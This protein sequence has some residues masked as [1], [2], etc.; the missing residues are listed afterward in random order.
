MVRRSLLQAEILFQL[1]GKPAPTITELAR[2]VNGKRPSVSRSLHRLEEQGQVRH[3]QDGWTLTEEGK[4]E[5]PKAK[6]R[7]L[8]LTEE[9]GNLAE[10]TGNVVRRTGTLAFSEVIQKLGELHEPSV[11]NIAGDQLETLRTALKT[12]TVYEEMSRLIESP[13]L[14]VAEQIN[15][16]SPWAKIHQ[17]MES[18]IGDS[19]GPLRMAV[20]ATRIHGLIEELPVFNL[21]QKLVDV[22]ELMFGTVA[23]ES[24]IRGF[25]EIVPTNI[26]PM[27]GRMIDVPDLNLAIQE[28]VGPLLRTQ[29]LNSTLL[30]NLAFAPQITG[31][32]ELARNNHRLLADAIDDVLAL[33]SGALADWPDL[34]GMIDFPHLLPDFVDLNVAYEQLFRENIGRLVL[35]PP[36]P[37]Y[38]EYLVPTVAV[39]SYAG[40]VR[41][42]IEEELIPYEEPIQQPRQRNSD[43]TVQEELDDMLA[44]LDVK[45]V[46]MR[47]GCWHALNSR[48]PDYQRHAAVSQRELVVQVL[49]HLVP[50]STLPTDA[51]QGPQL[52]ARLMILA[53][54][55]K[56]DREF[57][58]ALAVAVLRAYDQLNKYTHRDQRQESALRA[59][60]TAGEALL[61]FVLSVWRGSEKDD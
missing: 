32:E 58:E 39:S 59:I 60:L 43:A 45:F 30:S 23:G 21:A 19:T 11:I 42:L 10:R 54:H 48:G 51:R 41:D 18:S 52:K 24:A 5:V 1:E 40:S 13:L 34:A 47:Q 14:A 53:A 61:S 3:S 9:A 37:S 44:S 22:P 8:S 27:F 26:L 50:T 35:V 56:S 33:R 38:Q 36:L 2:R 29:E 16:K 12:A 4:L 28:A 46:T 25:G 20:E 6:D 57:A 17:H 49:E 31:L 55:S 7:V 15:W